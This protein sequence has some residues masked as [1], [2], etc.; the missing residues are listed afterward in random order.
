M[1]QSYEPL[2]NTE[3]QVRRTSPL[4]WEKCSP[5]M[6]EAQCE[7]LFFSLII[8]IPVPKSRGFIGKES[9]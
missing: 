6:G 5:F 9:L 1:P 2:E 4:P 8:F 3:G 7:D